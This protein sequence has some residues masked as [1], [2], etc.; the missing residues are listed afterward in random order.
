MPKQNDSASCLC[1]YTT[2]ICQYTMR[3]KLVIYLCQ[4]NFICNISNHIRNP[5]SLSITPD[6][7]PSPRTIKEENSNTE[8][9]PGHHPCQGRLPKWR[10]SA[11]VPTAA[12]VQLLLPMACKP[13]QTD[14]GS[15][16]PARPA[17]DNSLP[18]LALHLRFLQLLIWSPYRDFSQLCACSSGQL[19]ELCSL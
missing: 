8:T 16:W 5:I 17:F 12:W 9:S 1:M 10:T 6:V 14:T 13:L 3:H 15:G 2:T 19:S 18:W 4:Q 7:T 11:S